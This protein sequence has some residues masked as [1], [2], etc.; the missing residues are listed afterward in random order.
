MA[1]AAI[2]AARRNDLWVVSL[3]LN[4]FGSHTVS[5]TLRKCCPMTPNVELSGTAHDA[6]KSKRG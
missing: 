3:D 5:L 4:D 6:P 2:Q 1:Q